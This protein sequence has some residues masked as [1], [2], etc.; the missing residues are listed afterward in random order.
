MLARPSCLL[1]VLTPIAFPERVQSLGGSRRRASSNETRAPEEFSGTSVNSAV[2]TSVHNPS[3]ATTGFAETTSSKPSSIDSFRAPACDKSPEKPVSPTPPFDATPTASGVI[4]YSFMRNIDREQPRESPWSSMAFAASNTASF[5]PWIST[6][7]SEPRI[8][9]T[10][11]TM[12]SF[13]EVARCGLRRSENGRCWRRD[14]DDPT[15]TRPRERSKTCFAGSFD[16]A[17]KS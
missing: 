16:R 3:R 8:S 10:D 4:A 9:S 12:R 1:S 5:R 6:C 14:S 15:R 13:G 17:M 7:W 2:A 11:S